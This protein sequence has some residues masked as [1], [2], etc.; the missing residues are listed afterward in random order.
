MGGGELFGPATLPECLK[1]DV[2]ETFR[3]H[4]EKNNHMIDWIER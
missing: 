3:F 2:I 1:F 4:I